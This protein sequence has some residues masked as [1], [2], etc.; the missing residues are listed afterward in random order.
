M[1]EQLL[2]TLMGLMTVLPVLFASP[3]AV[4]W[5][6]VQDPRRARPL[7]YLAVAGLGIAAFSP[8]RT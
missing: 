1:Y 3:I 5:L 8:Q 2:P 7:A 6:F 4:Y